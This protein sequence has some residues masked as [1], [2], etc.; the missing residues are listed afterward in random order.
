MNMDT[1]AIEDL[2]VRFHV[3]VPDEERA[4][5][6]RLLISVEM[7]LDFRAAAATDDLAKT[8]NYFEVQQTILR[9]GEGRQWK[10]IETLAEDVAA[11]VLRNSLVRVVRVE[12]KKFIL[13]NT[14]HV[15]VRIE[16]RG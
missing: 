9:L 6:Q 14:R 10:L 16:R 1:I 15:A 12:V 4:H 7:D 8:V 3:G 5:A 13:T 2:E 11:L